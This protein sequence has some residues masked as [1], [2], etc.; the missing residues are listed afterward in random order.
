[1]NSKVLINNELCNGCGNCVIACPGNASQGI[2]SK[3]GFGP[4]TKAA[5]V[6]QSWG[7]I[8]FDANVCRRSPTRACKECMEVC[9]PGAIS[10]PE[11]YGYSALEK[12]VIAANFCSG[13]GAC[14]AVCPEKVIA[15]DELPKLIG[16]CI[17]CGYCLTHCPRN[18]SASMENFSMN[19]WDLRGY[20]KLALAAR[21]SNVRKAQDGGFA[22]A[23]VKFALEKR[24]IDAAI[25]A[26]ED[27][28]QP[29]KAKPIL[30]TS[31]EEVEKGAGSKYSN[32]SNLALIREAKERGFKRVGIVGLPCQIEGLLK[33]QTS[34]NEDLG[35]Y[36]IIKLSIGLFCK[37]NFMYKGIKSLVEEQGIPF[38]SIFKMN[39]KG[40]HFVLTTSSGEITIPLKKALAAK[41]EG[42]KIC[43]DFTSK[44]SDFSVGSIGAP[45][46]F[47]TVFARSTLAVQMLEMMGSEGLVETRALES[48]DLRRVEDLAE[49]KK[50]DALPHLRYAKPEAWSLF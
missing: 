11:T 7:G 20:S 17:N 13:C 33:L 38:T 16:K 46:G 39:I 15:V 21:A 40:R 45:A 44:F 36:Q 41:R 42:C 10:Y 30:V 49:M 31:T 24:I 4:R 18:P 47:S 28:R 22:T 48:S 37:G 14:A 43:M 29:W 5:L 34:P 35:F 50:K 8:F 6:L 25:I 19:M 9:A 3:G 23:L 27:A 26:G 2:D 12:E 1:M 32:S